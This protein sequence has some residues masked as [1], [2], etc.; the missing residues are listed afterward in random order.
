MGRAVARRRRRDADVTLGE[1]VAVTRGDFTDRGGSVSHPAIIDSGDDVTLVVHDLPTAIMADEQLVAGYGISPVPP[2]EADL[3]ALRVERE[4]LLRRVA[5]IDT[6]LAAAE[7][8][9][10]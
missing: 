3:T 2:A 9:G 7:A 1:G 8:I 6:L 5:E 10:D 4:K